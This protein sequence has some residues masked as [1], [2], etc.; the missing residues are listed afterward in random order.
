M[1]GATFKFLIKQRDDAIEVLEIRAEAKDNEGAWK[2]Y[3]KVEAV[4]HRL[5][6]ECKR[7]ETDE[8]IQKHLQTALTWE[9]KA[10]RKGL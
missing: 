2:Q 5:E 1:Y 7:Y 3:R 9:Q 10:I 4:C 6:K 8:E